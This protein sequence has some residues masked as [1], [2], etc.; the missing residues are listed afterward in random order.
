[1]AGGKKTSREKRDSDKRHKIVWKRR[2][3]QVQE[4]SNKEILQKSWMDI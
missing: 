2:H 1:M 3:F 4:E